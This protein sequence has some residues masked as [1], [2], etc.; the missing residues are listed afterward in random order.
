[1]FALAAS[2]DGQR[3]Y[4]GGSFTALGGDTAHAYVGAVDPSAGRVDQSFQPEFGAD[5]GFPVLALTADSRGVYAGGGGH[6]GH[7]AI[8]NSDGS[9]Q[10][11]IYQTDGGVQA[12][13]VDGSSLYAGGHFANYCVGNAGAGSPYVCDQPAQRRKIFE[14]S[15]DSGALTA[16]APA[17]NSAHGVFTESVDPSSH[18]LYVGGDFTTVNGAK[19]ARLAWF[20]S[21]TT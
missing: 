16:W 18:A 7:L 4:V 17:L 9:L 5:G 2:V 15:L 3:I 19:Q 11:D 10:R 13:A 21:V 6:G 14:V 20:R 1:V 8:W 12:V